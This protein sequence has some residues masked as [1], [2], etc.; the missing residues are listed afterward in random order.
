[1]V[2]EGSQPK[3]S[4]KDSNLP[5]GQALSGT[6]Y[7][8]SIPIGNLDDITIRA[9]RILQNVSIIASEN[10]A[11]TQALLAHHHAT[12]TITS[13]GPRNLDDKVALLL[14]H[15]RKGHDVALVSDCGTP[16]IYDPGCQLISEAHRGGIPVRAV[17]GASALTAAVAVSGCPGD[18]FVFEGHLPRPG[19]SLNT[20]L[21]RL[22]GERRT[23][24]FFV[25][26]DSIKLTLLAI[27]KVFPTRRITIA[28]DL[29]KPEETTLQGTAHLLAKNIRCV[30]KGG[31]VAV[32]IEGLSSRHQPKQESR[33]I[34]TA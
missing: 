10:P 21:G 18:A 3:A 6:L 24:V 5:T 14:N 22:R 4:K 12:G 13:Y 23:L 34:P 20:F 31:E 8:V 9:L 29:T 30:R 2:R 27:A 7:V 25:A 33:Y 16:V 11:E 1:M 26:S 19:R 32:V 28:Q 15:L 17:P